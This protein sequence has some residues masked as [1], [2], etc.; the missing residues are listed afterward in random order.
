[1]DNGIGMCGLEGLGVR[2]AACV[3]G[4]LPLSETPLGPALGNNRALCLAD[5]WTEEKQYF[6]SFLE[7][8]GSALT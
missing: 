4:H 7:G 2:A 6:L 3:E 8:T 5:V 1:M